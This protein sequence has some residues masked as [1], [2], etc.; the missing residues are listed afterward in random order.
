HATLD[1][2]RLGGRHG[3]H[4]GGG[5]RRRDDL[6]RRQ[7]AGRRRRRPGLLH[8][9]FLRRRL[10]RA[11]RRRHDL[12]RHRGIPLERAAPLGRPLR[13]AMAESKIAPKIVP[14]EI[15]V[16]G[17]S[18]SYGAIRFR[19]EVVRDCS[20]KIERGKL[21]VMVGPSGCGKSTLIRLL[22]GFEQPTAGRVTLDGAPITEPSRDRLVVFQETALFPWMTTWDNILYGPR[23]RGE[24]SRESLAF[25]EF[26]LSKVGLQE[27]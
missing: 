21:T 18:K 25:G 12:D 13:Y 9:E 5:G 17:V 20:F 14:G 15:V 3:H 24:L 1:R 19:K 16:E 22:A 23:A 26:L 27:F 10:L 11:D 6:G 2:G 4:L 7:P 8:L